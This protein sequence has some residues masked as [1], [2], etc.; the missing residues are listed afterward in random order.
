MTK[1][2]SLARFRG[3]ESAQRAAMGH[4]RKE[5]IH[6]KIIQCILDGLRRLPQLRLLAVRPQSLFIFIQEILELIPRLL[7]IL[8]EAGYIFH[9]I[10]LLIFL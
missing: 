1:H 8:Y 3:S 2:A 7:D 6:Y 10:S 5:S 9:V 4:T